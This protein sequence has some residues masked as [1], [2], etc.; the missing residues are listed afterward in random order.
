MAQGWRSDEDQEN[1]EARILSWIEIL[2]TAR[3]EVRHY[4]DLYRRAMVNRGLRKATGE[5]LSYWI[6]PE[7]LI[8]EHAGLL[9][10]LASAAPQD[11]IRCSQ[12]HDADQDDRL[13]IY[14]VGGSDEIALPCHECRPEAHR[15]RQAEHIG[16][17]AEERRRRP[18]LESA[19]PEERG[20]EIK[21]IGAQIAFAPALP[22]EVRYHAI[23]AQTP[24]VIID[25]AELAGGNKDMLR[26]IRA[27][28]E[29]ANKLDELG[30]TE[31]DLIDDTAN[32]RF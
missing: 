18:K 3:I 2:G 11:L 19:V 8:A 21:P 29:R 17:A 22:H 13:N 30:V 32:D 24:F 6:T 28:M 9:R 23:R 4:E 15:K 12:S 16:L 5:S 27:R 25:W 20:G 26:S 31:E 7:E 10:D 1:H 14:A